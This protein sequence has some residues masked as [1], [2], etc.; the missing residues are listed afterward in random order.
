MN[1]PADL[2][3]SLEQNVGSSTVKI[4]GSGGGCIS[5]AALV[6]F[7]SGE[8][9]FLKWNP[10]V[11]DDFFGKEARGLEEL[12]G[13]DALHVP[14]V[15][16]VQDFQDGAACPFILMEALKVGKHSAAEEK[17]LGMGLAK[18][19]QKKGEKFGFFENNYIGSLPQDNTQSVSGWGEFFVNHRLMKQAE[20][21]RENGWFDQSFDELFQSTKQAIVDALN[22]ADDGPSLLHGDLWGGNVFWS[23]NG[24]ALIDPAVYYGCREADVAFTE[25]FGG[26]SESFFEGYN[27]VL[28]LRSGYQERK[29]LHNLYHLMT[30]SNLFGGHY[31]DSA[32]KSLKDI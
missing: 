28:P 10:D 6:N 7:D 23:S 14:K 27:A 11:P 2:K 1:L 32:R 21:G 13:V 15:I 12:A 22:E 4:R 18:L 5:Q 25:L 30:H 20:L 9:Y 16:C 24:P 31:I 3:S 19:H 29:P 26:F 17:E 8:E